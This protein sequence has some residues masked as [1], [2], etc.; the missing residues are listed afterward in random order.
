VVP[1][2]HERSA[3]P[4]PSVMNE[5]LWSREKG[6]G[7]GWDKRKGVGA[8]FIDFW[9][10]S[11][12]HRLRAPTELYHL[13]SLLPNRGPGRGWEPAVRHASPTPCARVRGREDS[14]RARATWVSASRCGR[15]WLEFNF[16]FVCFL[17]LSLKVFSFT[18]TR[19]HLSKIKKYFYFY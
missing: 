14:V 4:L 8:L 5:W 18:Q 9:T 2:S 7:N 15:T 13:F 17:L 1:A 3:S 16:S 11:P 6:G 10:A 12:V 19:P